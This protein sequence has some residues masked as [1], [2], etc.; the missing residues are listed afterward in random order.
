MK[1]LKENQIENE[2]LIVM[3]LNCSFG[4]CLTPVGIFRSR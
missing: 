1:S 2:T 3:K 4:Y